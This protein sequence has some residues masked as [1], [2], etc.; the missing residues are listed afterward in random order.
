MT[1]VNIAVEGITDSIVAKRLL[2]HV[3]CTV[4]REQ[5][6]KG[7]AYLLRRLSD[8]NASARFEF[9]FIIVDLDQEA[10][11][12]SQAIERWLPKSLH[13]TRLCL[14]V[15][16]HEIESWLIADVRHLAAFLEVSEARFPS[17]P[18]QDAHPK[19]TLINIARTSRNRHVRQDMVP[20]QSIS[21]AV[22]PNYVSRIIEFTQN[23]WHPEE[24]AIRS[25][26]LRRCIQALKSLSLRE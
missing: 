6:S 20:T 15:A 19:Q 24:A 16:V 14:R 1:Y 7:K 13:E 17:L 3:G 25:E 9:W 18:D 22:G 21:R 2:K 12:A 26:S 5:G 10:F 4:G 8:Y 23:Y 11:C